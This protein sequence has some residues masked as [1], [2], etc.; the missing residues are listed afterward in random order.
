MAVWSVPSSVSVRDGPAGRLSEM[1][2][3]PVTVAV[4]V[5][6]PASAATAVV[7]AAAVTAVRMRSLCRIWVIVLPQIGERAQLRSGASAQ[8]GIP[9]SGQSRET[10]MGIGVPEGAAV[11]AARATTALPGRMKN[12]CRMSIT[13]GRPRRKRGADR[14]EKGS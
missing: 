10:A 9:R 4:A 7:R 12:R 8:S 3:V 1:P 13:I 14:Y 6:L 2:A 5:K 11:A